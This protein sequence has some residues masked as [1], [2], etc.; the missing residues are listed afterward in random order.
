VASPHDGVYRS[1]RFAA[2]VA[3]RDRHHRSVGVSNVE[4]CERGVDLHRAS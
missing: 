1:L 3:F 2:A 4:V